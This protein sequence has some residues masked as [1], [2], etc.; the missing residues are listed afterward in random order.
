MPP[1]GP[2]DPRTGD[3]FAGGGASSPPPPPED[4]MR[5]MIEELIAQTELYSTT[6]EFRQLLTFVARMRRFAPFNAMLLHIQKPG[7]THAAT[8]PDWLHRFGRKPK[9]HARPLL[10]LRAM[11]PVDFVFDIL[12][13]EGRDV[14]TD[15]FAFPTFN[16]M[17]EARFAQLVA[18]F[19]KAGIELI[20]TS[21]R[22]G[23]AGAIWVKA[24]SPKPKGRHSYCIEY[25]GNHPPATR[26]VTLAHELAHLFLG[27]LGADA[28]RGVPDRRTRDH[29]LREVEA[30]TVA[31]LVARRSGV[32]PRS[33]TY[34]D[35]VKGS[36]RELDFHAVMRAVNQ[37][38]RVF[39]IDADTL[40]KNP[41]G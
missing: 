12:D 33:E 19:P 39:G 4:A 13:T 36:L 27:H 25:N 11:G 31:Y 29:A 5:A 24:R 30:E 32:T 15:A 18:G 34:L 20:V 21:H 10:V 1:R 14:P 6:A 35:A 23:A 28:G 9:R 41:P 3:L 16:Q 40:W 2:R 7:L 8:R 38:E 26:F 17:T 37:I 22:D